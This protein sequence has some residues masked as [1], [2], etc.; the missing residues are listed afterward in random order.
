MEI[1]IAGQNPVTCADSLIELRLLLQAS[2]SSSTPD[3]LGW[4]PI[5]SIIIT[6]REMKPRAIRF[7]DG[8][9]KRT[10]SLYNLVEHT[11]HW[12]WRK[13]ALTQAQAPVP[14][15][16]GGT[17]YFIRAD[18]NGNSGPWQPIGTSGLFVRTNLGQVSVRHV[19]ELLRH[20]GQSA[21]GIYIQ[22]P[23]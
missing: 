18:A 17:D 9:Q 12:L 21:E 2:E 1:R 13:G 22:A 4:A 16:P 5:E 23:C 6:P 19:E 10:P 3:A 20:C 8:E 14:V 15:K 11:A 7:P